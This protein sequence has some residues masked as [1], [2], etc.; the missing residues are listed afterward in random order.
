MTP[1]AAVLDPMTTMWAALA[2][3][4]F[5]VVALVARDDAITQLAEKVRR[6]ADGEDVE[7]EADRD[8]EFGDL[9]AAVEKLNETVSAHERTE[10]SAERYR[11]R[12]DEIV[13]DSGT[14]DDEKIAAVV[15][16][17]AEV[18]GVENAFVTS[19]NEVTDN[20]EVT[21]ALGDGFPENE[22]VTG[23]IDALCRETTK[24]HDAVLGVPNLEAIGYEDDDDGEVAVGCFLG[25]EIF[26]DRD[27]YGTVCF[28][29]DEPRAEGFS[30]VETE[31]ADLVSR[32]IGQVFERRAN[33]S[34][35][36]LASKTMEAAP[37]GVTILDPSRDGYPI[38]AVNEAFESISGYSEEE[39]IG[40]SW[41]FLHG[42][43][44]D[45]EAAAAI[46]WA[47]DE[48]ESVSIELRNYRKDGTPFW[49]RVSVAPVLD[50]EGAVAYFVLFQEDVTER[51]E[52]ERQT[53]AL[54]ENTIHPIFIKDLDGV[55]QFMN[56]A[57]AAYFD[58]DPADA[59]GKRDEELF[60]ADN[61]EDVRRGDGEVLRTGRAITMET[62][63]TIDGR[64]HIFSDNKYP[65]LDRD[66]SVIGVMGISQDITDR[67]SSESELERTQHLLQQTERLANLGGWELDVRNGD[68]PTL[69]WTDEVYRIHDLPTDADVTLDDAIDFYHP[70]D[71]ER[72]REGVER[73]LESAEQYDV[74]ARL[75]T[76]TGRNRWVW[77][78]GD[79]VVVDGDVVAVRGSVQDITEQKERA[80]ELERTRNLLGQAGRMAN[81][82]GWEL[83][84]TTEPPTLTWTDSLTELH[85]LPPETEID[86]ETALSLYRP[87]D[88]RVIREKIQT[89]IETGT[90]YEIVARA[91]TDDST[92]GWVRGIA[93]AVVENDEVVRIRGAIQDITDQKE[94]ELALES[95]HEST[96]G[97]LNTEDQAAAAKLVVDAAESVLDVS[98]FCIFLFDEGTN[99]LRPV[100]HS[101][102]FREYCKRD[103]VPI[104]PED[105]SLLWRSFVTGS[106]T[107][108]DDA[109]AA[110]EPFVAPIKNGLVVPIGPHGVFVAIDQAKVIDDDVRQLVE[111]LVATAEEAFSRIQTETELRERDAELNKQNKQLRRQIRINETIRSVHQSL[112]GA[113]SREAL[114][115]TVCERLVSGEDIEFAWVGG[116]VAS[117]G[118]VVP[119]AWAGEDRG[120]LDNVSFNGTAGDREPAAETADTGTP[121]VVSNVA[122]DIQTAPWRQHA[123][124]ANFQSVL[125]VPLAFD[126]YSYGFVAVYAN[127]P[128]T[129]G[130]LEQK[131]FT[132]LGESI[133][134]A[135]ASAST[136]QALQADRAI[137]LTLRLEGT[138][139]L[140]TAIAREAGCE[141]TYLGL[142]TYLDDTARLFVRTTG[143]DG[144]V[145]ADALDSLHAV[146]A[147][148][149][150]SESDDGDVFE[151]DHRGTSIV[152]KLVRHGGRPSSIRADESGLT[153]EVDIHVSADVRTFVEMLGEEYDVELR[154]RRERDRSL[155]TRQSVLESILGDLTD[156]QREV[157]QTAYYAGFF[158]WPRDTTGEGL[159]AMLDVSQPTVN[160]HLRV[161][162]QRIMRQLFDPETERDT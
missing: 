113:T 57:A 88:R 77:A 140:L 96:R 145:V 131:V 119:R 130:D 62:A 71:R 61:L 115:S 39:S 25:A 152:T 38:I 81:F 51:S 60:E 66:G 80:L 21:T 64:E 5:G 135:I 36:R 89:A 28:V 160:R 85:G 22:P 59:I 120:Y 52:Q 26:V 65:Y 134:N 70:D 124:A 75:I 161:A 127:E 142:S 146:Q 149:H 73:A 54:I 41:Q 154:S 108:I 148:R 99:V 162:E 32:W 153:V 72:V 76:A 103:P 151:V 94:R 138:T 9:C 78:I 49:N 87:E 117:T 30:A 7:F 55:Y 91:K 18:F 44:T 101:E 56:E 125:A 10:A 144:S 3:L 90:G 136:K 122:R 137:S 33:T 132:E 139:D 102:G 46:Q 17:G 48:R 24:N 8:D 11:Q 118:A 47:L 69:H 29:G 19:L 95:L 104:G 13:A 100:A 157:L 126:E 74:E 133:A 150:V 116:I 2:C 84:V 92:F 111:T 97:L 82:G 40:E 156:R 67:K 45:E 105:G 93:E 14:S 143:V 6:A 106:L 63:T 50:D 12:F 35:L 79:P 123:L 107:V 158:N 15:E 112:V 27:L 53:A 86:L 83:D 114:E 155:Q 4:A 16:L 68:G 147:Y 31:F 109:A 129:F 121:T 58:L 128:R 42:T 23:V 34:S 1:I 37:V 110:D 20:Y 43:G 141:V 98:V 159:A